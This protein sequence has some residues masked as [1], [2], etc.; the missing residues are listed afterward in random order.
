MTL[1]ANIDT[2]GI[3]N[4]GGGNFVVLIFSDSQKKIHELT[5]SETF[6][7]PKCP[8]IDWSRTGYPCKHF[9]AIFNK[10]P[11]WSWND[12]SKVCT[13]S[14]FLNLDLEVIPIA[15]LD[16]DDKDRRKNERTVKTNSYEEEANNCENNYD[17][18]FIDLSRKRT[19]RDN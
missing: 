2:S 14:P 11:S 18:E 8:C 6:S 16:I 19:W 3:T 9:F 10:S 12:L 15:N 4:K 5:F 7:M 17:F 1:A 13:E